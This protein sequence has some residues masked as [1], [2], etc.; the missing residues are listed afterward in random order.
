MRV[1]SFS[2]FKS[3]GKRPGK[4]SKRK[5]GYFISP[6]R[7]ARPKIS[8]PRSRRRTPF[9]SGGGWLMMHNPTENLRLSITEWEQS[10]AF[11]TAAECETFVATRWVKQ[12]R[13]TKS[14]NLSGI[15]A[16]PPMLFIHKL[17]LKNKPS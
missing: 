9:S 4:L 12:K 1:L 10:L 16:C 11:D 2:C 3:D 13:N 8:P 15:G 5:L 7:Y 17:S 6:I 14:F